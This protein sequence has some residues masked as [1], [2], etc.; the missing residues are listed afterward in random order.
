MLFFLSVFDPPLY[1]T[2]NHLE[3]KECNS[4]GVI[5]CVD[6]I[7]LIFRIPS[8]LKSQNAFLDEKDS[9]PVKLDGEIFP[10]DTVPV[11]TAPEI[12]LPMSWGF[13]SFN[14]RLVINARSETALEKPMFKEAML[15][16]RCLIPASGYY[17]WETVNGKK[18]RYAFYEENA[19]LFLAGCYRKEKDEDLFRFV[20]LTRDASDHF[21]Y[22]HDR[23]PVIIPRSK[24]R[25]GSSKGR[26]PWR[27][28]LRIQCFKRCWAHDDSIDS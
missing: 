1:L 9:I 20:I 25:T 13:T 18:Q 11:R 3:W 22:V 7:I 26:M 16:R 14:K 23:M 2:T 21:R 5:L 19:L 28:L 24:R 6:A 17:E 4:K 10:S 27:M 8:F 12:Y 15:E